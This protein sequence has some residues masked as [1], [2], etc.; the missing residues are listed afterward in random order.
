MFAIVPRNFGVMLKH[1]NGSWKL[2][3]AMCI[4]CLT[5]WSAQKS[6]WKTWL[7]YLL[8]RS[9]VANGIL[10]KLLLLKEHCLTKHEKRAGTLS[11]GLC[12][13]SFKVI[14]VTKICWFVK[15]IGHVSS[16]LTPKFSKRKEEFFWIQC[17]SL[18]WDPEAG[19]FE[20]TNR[21]PT[22]QM[23]GWMMCFTVLESC[24]PKMI[25]A[26][27]YEGSCSHMFPF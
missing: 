16:Q 20:N 7:V 27:V 13:K 14:L 6:H 26:F 11:H 21:T 4:D 25:K 23:S 24:G 17:G 10:S 18:G 8:I 9:N 3:M 22:L 2:C 5:Q 15:G 19:S 1:F 12:A